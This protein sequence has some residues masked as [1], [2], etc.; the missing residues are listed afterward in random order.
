MIQFKGTRSELRDFLDKNFTKRAQRKMQLDVTVHLEPA[1]D[2][3][4]QRASKAA[5]AADSKIQAIKN[6]REV[7]GAGLVEAKNEVE[8]RFPT[9]W[10]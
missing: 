8:A 9:R 3:L 1:P 10:L 4:I 2:T 5:L 7:T 6:W